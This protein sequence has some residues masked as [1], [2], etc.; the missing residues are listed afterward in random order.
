[1]EGKLF[2]ESARTFKTSQ[3]LKIANDVKT[4]SRALPGSGLEM[5]SKDIF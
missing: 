2:Y 5:N 1:M 3:P 4:R